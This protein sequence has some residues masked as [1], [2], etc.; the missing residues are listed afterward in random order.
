MLQGWQIARRYYTSYRRLARLKGP[1]V[2]ETISYKN[3]I[4]NL[5]Q[6]EISKLSN[7]LT[8]GTQR[9]ASEHTTVGL[10]VN[11]GPRYESAEEHG[12]T[13]F[14]EH[15]AFQ[16]T[17]TRSRSELRNAISCAGANFKSFTTREMTV[18]F[19]Q[20]LS[21]DVPQILGILF[22]CIF[23]NKLEY[24]VIEAQKH[25]LS[26]EI[27]EY[28]KN[29]SDILF[30]YLHMSAFQGTPLEQS[31]LGPCD[32]VSKFNSKLLSRILYQRFTPRNMV[33]TAIGGVEHNE[34]V[35][36]SNKYLSKMVHVERDESAQCRYTGADLRYRNDA[37]PMAHVAVAMEGP[38][39]CHADYNVLTLAKEVV[40]G[41]D[42]AQ[43][44]GLAHGTSVARAASYHN[45]CDSYKSFYIAYKDTALWGA[46]FV[47]SR[48]G[49]D[50]M[51]SL[52]QY[53]WMNLC[54]MITEEQLDRAKNQLKTK[55]LSISESGVR[56]SHRVGRSLLYRGCYLPVYEGINVIDNITVQDVKS[57]CY[58]YLY[59]KCPV[60][61]ATGPTETLTD[62]ARVRSGT[63]W[64]RL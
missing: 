29:Y 24:N 45:I 1:C 54:N 64:I 51:V 11:A 30:D 27:Q 58:K 9:R 7:G 49:L 34:I 25:L 17:K 39:Y 6:I 14:L 5:P 48:L 28:E 60:V 36:L 52:L 47:G 43:L 59:D 23:N 4:R 3:I 15:I 50:D 20:C 19:T 44:G 13:H 26:M 32:N 21:P 53:E 12:T 42:K 37:Q 40:G 63:Y 18:Y 10:Y 57:V 33:I 16:S 56:T 46:Y 38:S 41:W 61:A 31:V 62:Y 2:K 35:E 22:E 55:W 8:I